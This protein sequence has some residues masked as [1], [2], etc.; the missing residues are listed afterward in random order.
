MSLSSGLTVATTV[1]SSFA[2]ACRSKILPMPFCITFSVLLSAP[3]YD[4]VMVV[5]RSSLAVF[6]ST[7]NDTL[8]SATLRSV[9]HVVEHSA[10]SS[11]PSTALATFTSTEASPPRAFISTP[12]V[13]SSMAGGSTSSL[14]SEQL[15][16]MFR[17]ASTIIPRMVPERYRRMFIY[18]SYIN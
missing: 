13:V 12:W 1:L 9:T 5:S 4:R 18:Y 14:S 16:H 17:H 3:V 2:A 6:G 7:L 10:F 11:T 15:Q 8:L